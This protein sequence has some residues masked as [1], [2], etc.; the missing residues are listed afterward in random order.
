MDDPDP[1]VDAIINAALKPGEELPVGWKTKAAK[2]TRHLLPDL[3]ERLCAGL[4][5][6]Y[7]IYEAPHTAGAIY[8]PMLPEHGADNGVRA[9]M[10]RDDEVRRRQARGM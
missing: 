3:V 5:P 7:R 10:K 6:T 2:M 9:R 8:A 4:A 1:V